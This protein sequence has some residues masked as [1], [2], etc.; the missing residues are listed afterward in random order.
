M[1]GLAIPLLCVYSKEI[2]IYIQIFTAALLIIT[3]KW[4]QSKYPPTDIWI[5]KMWYIYTME[6]STLKKE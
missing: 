2:K 1:Y 3:K 5:N 4:K 6:Y